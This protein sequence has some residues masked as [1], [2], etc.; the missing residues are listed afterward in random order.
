MVVY[1]ETSAVLAWLFGETTADA[2]RRTVDEAE[3]IV[4][5]VITVVETQRAL[6]RAEMGGHIAAADRQRLRGL[7]ARAQRGWT[8]MEVSAEVRE[9]AGGRFP[10]EP[11]R[12]RDGVHLATA[13][14]FARAYPD[15]Q[16]FS[17]DRWILVNATA[18]GLALSPA[19]SVVDAEGS[20]APQRLSVEWS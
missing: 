6:V 4:T 15:L 2:V 18:L 13:L 14:A 10:V 16:V 19:A 12:T 8:M 3:M 11:L 7:L 20:Q 17:L 1:L 9:M 5:S